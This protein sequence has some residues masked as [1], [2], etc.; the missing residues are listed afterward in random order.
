MSP[1]FL[2]SNNYSKV[3]DFEVTIFKVFEHE[4][5]TDT[6]QVMAYEN[7]T[8]AIF[9]SGSKVVLGSTERD[10]LIALLERSVQ[11]LNVA[12]SEEIIINKRVEVGKVISP[13]DKT[14]QIR[15]SVTINKNG[16][17]IWCLVASRWPS[18]LFILTEQQANDFI[19]IIE[20]SEKTIAEINRQISL[21]D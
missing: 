3:G 8:T 6:Y 4:Y 1:I 2:F 12:A 7:D 11:F 10:E 16:S 18:L 9:F 17:K 13:L 20:E 19:S 21:F 5:I 14:K 15:L